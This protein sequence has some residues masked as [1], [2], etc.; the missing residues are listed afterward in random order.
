MQTFI[1]IGASGSGKS[2]WAKKY[3]KTHPKTRIVSADDFF[4]QPGD[5]SYTFD[6]KQLPQAHGQCL[7]EAIGTFLASEDAAANEDTQP[8]DALIIDNTNTTIA[9]VAPY[10]ALAQAFG[11]KVIPL[12]FE[13][14]YQGVHGVPRST[15]YAQESRIEKML[16]EWPVYWQAFI[17]ADEQAAELPPRATP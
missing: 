17:Y 14:R 13:L 4:I 6:P 8:Y 3:A 5:G 2:T 16:K 1:L 7:R 15:I 10:V 9:E 11:S 12:V